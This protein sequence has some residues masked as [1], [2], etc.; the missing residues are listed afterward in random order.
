MTAGGNA[1]L[2]G[3]LHN[4]AFAP[5]IVGVLGDGL[6]VLVGDGDD[7]ALQVF[8]EVEAH[9]AVVQ[10]A[11]GV[12]VI[13]QGDDL[14]IVPRFPQDLGAVQGVGMLHA[15]DGFRSP[16]AVGVIGVGIAVE[17]LELAALFP[18]QSVAQITGGVTLLLKSSILSWKSNVN[19]QKNSR[20][21]K[22]AADVL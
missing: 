4:G 22:D 12:L 8:E 16:D 9:A 13:I 1:T 3:I 7:V 11:D 6:A 10:A 18:C 19:F 2:G 15:V 14:G 5:G 17:G 21:P 20:T